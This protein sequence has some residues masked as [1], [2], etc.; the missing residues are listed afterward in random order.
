MSRLNNTS[1]WTAVIAVFDEIDLFFR[2]HS[3]I[4]LSLSASA[5]LAIAFFLSA[6][7]NRAITWYIVFLAP[8][9]VLQLLVWITWLLTLKFGA[10]CFGVA[11]S[12]VITP[13]FLIIPVVLALT[14]WFRRVEPPHYWDGLKIFTLMCL[15]LWS[16]IFFHLH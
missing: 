4:I 14:I 15:F 3:M 16:D 1:Q 10:F 13:S 8:A 2:H 11:A 6:N 9:A 5:F 12:L 7:R